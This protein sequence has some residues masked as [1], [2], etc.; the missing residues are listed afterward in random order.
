[1]A[2]VRTEHVVFAMIE[3]G[4]AAVTRLHA[5]EEIAKATAEKA[6]GQLMTLKRAEDAAGLASWVAETF[7]QGTGERGRP[8]PRE[9]EVR[10]YSV[11]AV[12]TG[13]AFIRLPVSMIGAEKGAKVR[14]SFSKDRLIVTV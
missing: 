5:K 7:P 3:N 12:N 8:A 10:E 1:M 13:D 11:Q 2:N 6:V 14:V 9:G 4:V